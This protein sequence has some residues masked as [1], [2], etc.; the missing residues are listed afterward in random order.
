MAIGSINSKNCPSDNDLLSFFRSDL[1]QPEM[2]AVH[3]HVETCDQCLLFVDRVGEHS[4][5]IVQA[6][7]A[8]S[9]TIDDE[10]AY[11]ALRDQ[12]LGSPE[13]V[14]GTVSIDSW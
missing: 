6:L 14:Q 8:M 7:S 1:S 9:P 12:L 5:T 11:H 10:P 13:A 3:R 4:D 2:D